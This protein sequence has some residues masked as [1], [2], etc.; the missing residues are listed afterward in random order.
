ML[1]PPQ[2]ATR[3]CRIF[4]GFLVFQIHAK[5]NSMKQLSAAFAFMLSEA[6]FLGPQFAAPR[7]S[8]PA[9]VVFC[10]G[11]EGGTDKIT[12]TF[13]N[14][15]LGEGVGGVMCLPTGLCGCRPRC[16][17]CHAVGWNPCTAR[18]SR[19]SLLRTMPKGMPPNDANYSDYGLSENVNF[20][21]ARRTTRQSKES[22]QNWLLF[23]LTRNHL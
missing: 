3:T 7:S 11:V 17:C 4:V 22:H 10:W 6:A 9:V 13:V 15:H 2:R 20:A 19:R 8:Q 12:E 1:M 16:V 14:A 5:I 18:F 23:F 21:F